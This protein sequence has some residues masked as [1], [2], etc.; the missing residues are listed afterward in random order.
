VRDDE[1][2]HGDQRSKPEQYV[3]EVNSRDIVDQE[4]YERLVEEQ[5]ND[6]N[7]DHDQPNPPAWAVPPT[8]RLFHQV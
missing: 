6:Q 5:E 8:A 1:T 2:D 3:G 7:H 4:L